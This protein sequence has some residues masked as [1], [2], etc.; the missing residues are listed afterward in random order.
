MPNEFEEVFTTF[1]ATRAYEELSKV[2]SFYDYV[3]YAQELKKSIQNGESLPSPPSSSYGTEEVLRRLD[4]LLQIVKDSNFPPD[5]AV[6]TVPDL[7]PTRDLPDKLRA[8]IARHETYLQHLTSRRNFFRDVNTMI[9]AL[10]DACKDSADILR[11]ALE[12]GVPDIE[13]IVSGAWY[14]FNTLIP[15]R[16]APVR[17]AAKDKLI[18]F[19][20]QLE[21]KTKEYAAWDALAKRIAENFNYD[22]YKRQ[23]SESL[24]REYET[25]KAD[26]ANA[27]RGGGRGGGTIRGTRITP[28]EFRLVSTIPETNDTVELWM[29]PASL[30]LRRP[31]NFQ[32][33]AVPAQ[34]KVLILAGFPSSKARINLSFRGEQGREVYGY[35]FEGYGGGSPALEWENTY[36]EQITIHATA[37][38]DNGSSI[39]LSSYNIYAE[40]AVIGWGYKRPPSPAAGEGD[41]PHEAVLLI[42]RA[43]QPREL[44]DIGGA[45]V[46]E[47]SVT[48]IPG[49]KIL[50]VMGFTAT[51]TKVNFRGK[52]SDGSDFTFW[53]NIE[54]QLGVVYRYIYEN[55]K[56]VG[57]II[58]TASAR[59]SGGTWRQI[60]WSGKIINGMTV[61]G[62]GFNPG[63]T[64]H[65]NIPFRVIMFA[66]PMSLEGDTDLEPHLK[67]GKDSI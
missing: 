63:E 2:K 17:E 44:P 8:Y 59:G 52:W 23:V 6:P 14:D 54:G 1:E 48:I 36:G 38:D 51:G 64:I 53:R 66:V 12:Q 60:L 65:S 15:N 58:F 19:D 32:P 34:A 46:A 43:D 62:A 55:P 42:V 47:G 31:P 35:Y 22:E 25:L 27:R 18:L 24:R 40:V 37:V 33:M 29:I 45:G 16:A 5:A 21:V 20:R 11:H 9:E 57:S 50:F 3:D 28:H 4:R 39:N 56:S 61:A 7:R 41:R 26:A 13:G 49:T 10:Y 30:D 67:K